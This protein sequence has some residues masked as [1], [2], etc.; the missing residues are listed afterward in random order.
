MARA[1]ETLVLATPPQTMAGHL[2]QARAVAPG[3][4]V[5]ALRCLRSRTGM[6]RLCAARGRFLRS[7][8]GIPRLCVGGESFEPV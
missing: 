3:P 8:T 1:L 5:C 4:P 2:E 6:P 7:R